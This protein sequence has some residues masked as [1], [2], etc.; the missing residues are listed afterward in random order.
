MDPALHHVLIPPFF[1]PFFHFSLSGYLESFRLRSSSGVAHGPFSTSVF[2]PFTHLDTTP[3]Q[4]A[5]YTTP[6]TPQSTSLHLHILPIGLISPMNMVFSFFSFVYTCFLHCTLSCSSYFCLSLAAMSVSLSLSLSLSF[7]FLI[8][9]RGWNL[10]FTHYFLVPF[11]LYFFGL[12][13]D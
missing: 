10:S 9:D 6:Y 2:F 12:C 3:A 7:S 8:V 13:L 5:L 1:P 4:A 11:Y